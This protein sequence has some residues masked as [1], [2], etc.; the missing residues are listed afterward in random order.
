MLAVILISGIVVIPALA[1]G[2]EDSAPTP[3]QRA[4]EYLGKV[5]ANL[6]VT[7]DDLKTACTDARLEMIDEAVADGAIT[8]DQADKIKAQIAEKDDTCFGFGMPFMGRGLAGPANGAG[9]L[10]FLD[11]AVEQGLI[12]QEQADQ[13]ITLGEQ[14]REQIKEQIQ[15]RTQQQDCTGPLGLLDAAVE[16]GLITQDEADQINTLGNQIREQLKE[17]IGD[18]AGI[19]RGFGGRMH[20]GFGIGCPN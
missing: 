16:N 10:G 5:A 14:I 13:I 4:E 18:G 9:P 2:S 17:K 1:Q 8:Q 12:T 11:K 15:E 19:M 7:L 20:G 3:Q 6:G